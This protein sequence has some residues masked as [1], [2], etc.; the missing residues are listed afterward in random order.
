[1]EGPRGK[2]CNKLIADVSY[3]VINFAFGVSRSR[4]LH[5]V[6]AVAAD[7]VICLKVPLPTLSRCS[8]TALLDYLVGSGKQGLRDAET[9]RLGGFE[10]DGQLD[11]DREL[12]RKLARFRA[13]QDAISIDR[14]VP[15]IID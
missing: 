15:I 8:K 13:P 4:A 9:K 14:C 1:M 2:N 12:D 6:A 7:I 11:F 10:I 5:P 3:G